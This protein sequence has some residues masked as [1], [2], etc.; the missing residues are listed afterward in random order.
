MRSFALGLSLVLVSALGAQSPRATPAPQSPVPSPQSPGS[1]LTI[2][3][4]TM[5]VGEEIW[6]RFGHDGIR[7]VDATT[8]TDTVYNWGT[9]DMS[10]PNFIQRFMTGNTQYWM[11]GDGMAET[12]TRYRYLN[13]SVWV[14][15]LDLTP[16]E[17][18]SL[19]EF[20]AWNARPEN[21]YY[22]YDYYNDNCATRVRDVLDRLLGGQVKERLS[23]RLT[24]TTY[25]FHTQRSLQWDR[26]VAL[27]TDIGLGELADV[28]LTEWQA[29]FLPAELREFVRGVQVRRADGSVRPLVKS[30]ATLFAAQRP[31]LP[32]TPP[33]VMIRNLLIG[34]AI[35]AALFLSAF[36]ARGGARLPRITFVTLATL[37]TAI[38]GLLGVILIIGWTATRHVFMVRNENVLQ[39]DPLALALAV[40]LPLAISWGKALNAA[41]TLSMVVLVIAI[42]GLAIQVLPWFNQTNGQVI[43]L[44]LPA[45]LALAW[46]VRAL[47]GAPEFS[48]R[49]SGA[50]R[51]AVSRSAA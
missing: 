2:Y 22:R 21:L 26:P 49:H 27:G 5:G 18:L 13:R 9:F 16:A 33:D 24:T 35:A 51:A 12:M 46:A 48:P 34:L 28:P 36:A 37:W 44:T 43:A 31:E 40:V 30:E 17:R 32:P 42:V 6:E 8:G 4:I 41:R 11:Q 45:H 47:T 14:Q 39:F 20:I 19:K 7:I 1:D 23:T 10:Q 15:E 29:A 25:R 3:L 50:A 38:N